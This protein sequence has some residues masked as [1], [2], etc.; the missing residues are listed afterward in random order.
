MRRDDDGDDGDAEAELD[1]VAFDSAVDAV[2]AV[3]ATETASLRAE[4]MRLRRQVA[5]LGASL[6]RE[7]EK[8]KQLKQLYGRALRA[9]DDS[10]RLMLQSTATTPVTRSAPATPLTAMVTATPLAA[11]RTTPDGAA[12]KSAPT[13]RPAK[14]QNA[15]A[16]AVAATFVNSD[17]DADSDEELMRPPAKTPTKTKAAMLTP[18]PTK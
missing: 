11:K 7:A 2:R 10:T 5:E 14:K 13:P 18:P 12:A 16:A 1:G 3:H 6:R 9:L 15:A 4:I 8:R 17:D